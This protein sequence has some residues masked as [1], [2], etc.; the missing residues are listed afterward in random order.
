[1]MNINKPS[2]KRK[3]NSPINSSRKSLLISAP[4]KG[5][6]FLNTNKIGLDEKTKQI[7]NTSSN[8]NIKVVR[9]LFKDGLFYKHTSYGET[10]N[11]NQR[12]IKWIPLTNNL[13]PDITYFFEIGIYG[14]KPG[15]KNSKHAIS[16]IKRGNHLYVFDPWGSNRNLLTNIASIQLKRI[17]RVPKLTVYNGKNLQLF[18]N[19]GICVGFSTAA[20]VYL[21]KLFSTRWKNIQN[22]SQTNFNTTMFNHF[23]NFVNSP[24]KCKQI[25][26]T[27]VLNTARVKFLV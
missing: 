20:L 14:Y 16:A 19:R 5:R 17:L 13:K 21:S 12:S 9:L 23:K 10:T 7:Y 2:V 22:V 25:H 8:K 1:M 11:I 26:N 4:Y 15:T 3:R 6:R 18:D 27:L 24:N